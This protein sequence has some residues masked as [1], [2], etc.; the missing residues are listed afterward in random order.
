MTDIATVAFTLG[1]VAYSVASTLF[2]LEL[3]RPDA[4][5]GFRRWGPWAMGVAAVLHATH[6]VGASLITRVCP[7]ASLQFALSLSALIAVVVFLAVRTRFRLHAVGAVVGPLALTFLVGA[8]FVDASRAESS[9]PRTLLMFHITANLVGVGLF[10]LAGAAGAFYLVQERRLKEKKTGGLSNKLP[11]LDA[12]DRAEHRL[13]LAGF[14]LLTFGIVSGAVFAGRL[15][16]SG[17]TELL[18]AALG[19]ATWL[20]VA[21]VLVMRAAA[22][23]RGRRAAWGTLAGVAC[24]VTVMLLYAVRAGGAG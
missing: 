1:V 12:L 24:V 8:Q 16:A 6:V 17:G 4:Q 14:P 15:G 20:L 10:L 21:A 9:G 18:R 3:A 19:Y 23:W 22:G 5:L 11:P 2:F 13:L 7:I